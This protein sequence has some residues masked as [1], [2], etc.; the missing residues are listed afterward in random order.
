MVLLIF[1]TIIDDHTRSTWTHLMTNKSQVSHIRKTF[2]HYIQNQF[3]T[4][5]KTT[6]SDNVSE[7]L[8]KK[9]ISLF[10]QFNIVHQLSMPYTPQQNSVV[11]RKHRHL[12][13]T[14]R[15]IKIHANL[16]NSFWGECVL[17]AT[18]LINRMSTPVLAWKSPLNFYSTKYHPFII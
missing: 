11:E 18:Y 8:G 13:D 17:T 6:R 12:L 14:A 2:Y 1:L 15:A 10:Q 5:I 16:P 3:Q 4:S 9:C 7:F